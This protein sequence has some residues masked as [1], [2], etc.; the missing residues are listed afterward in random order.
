M[1]MSQMKRVARV[2]DRALIEGLRRT[3]PERAKG[4]SLMRVWLTGAALAVALTST[5][6]FA[7]GVKIDDLVVATTASASQQ[8]AT[9]KAAKKFYQFWNTGDEASLKAAI[10]PSFT[11]RTLP[12]GRPQGPEGPAFASKN[13]RAAVADLSVEVKKMVVVG[14]YVTVHMEF[15]GHFTGSFGQTK[16]Q[17][18]AIDFIATDLLKITN[19]RITDNWHLEDNLTFLQQIG[20]V[21]K[22]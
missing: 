8:E 7:E 12:P 21:P 4:V 20:L 9:I 11:D 2:Y 15:K 1:T 16:G 18:Q 14:D 5:P 22:L 10:S 3:A 17:G 13:F 6:T 19:G